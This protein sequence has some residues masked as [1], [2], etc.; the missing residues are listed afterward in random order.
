MLVSDQHGIQPV[1]LAY[2]SD[3]APGSIYSR[4]KPVSSNTQKWQSG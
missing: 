4:A 2:P 1:T 3:H